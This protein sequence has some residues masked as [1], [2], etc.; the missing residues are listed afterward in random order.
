MQAHKIAVTVGQCCIAENPVGAVVIESVQMRTMRAVLSILGIF[1]GFALLLWFLKSS[2][3][4]QAAGEFIVEAEAKQAPT[5]DNITNAT[6][7]TFRKKSHVRSTSRMSRLS[8]ISQVQGTEEDIDRQR[9]L[10]DMKS[11]AVFYDRFFQSEEQNLPS[12]RMVLDFDAIIVEPDKS[13]AVRMV[14]EA[15]QYLQSEAL[16][17]SASD[18]Q[19]SRNGEDSIEGSNGRKR[20]LVIAAVD[21][22]RLKGSHESIAPID[23]TAGSPCSALELMR[24]KY[25]GIA[26]R[27]VDDC[28]SERGN[29]WLE[30]VVNNVR[31]AVTAFDGVILLQASQPQKAEILSAVD[32][33]I[34]DCPTLQ[35]NGKLKPL[36][37]ENFDN[38]QKF[39]RQLKNEM[40]M[41]LQFTVMAL[42]CVDGAKSVLPENANRFM[43]RAWAHDL[44]MICKISPDPSFT[45]VYQ[46][47][48]SAGSNVTL[49]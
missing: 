1:G 4:F 18:A 22:R 46:C 21:C 24:K 17:Q 5:D 47:F 42:E 23:M 8:T 26:L 43:Q 32:G 19:E 40:S 15:N 10:A 2:S 29:E 35:R 27:N 36:Y 34:F 38:V 16:N 39:C 25:D 31:D 49:P 28:I 3:R 48:G 33:V 14:R 20:P 45:D 44:P 6:A 41:R 30:M 12:V 11:F 7:G 13:S 9:Q 37:G